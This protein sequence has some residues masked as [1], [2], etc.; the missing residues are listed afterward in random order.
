MLP[1]LRVSRPAV[2]RSKVVL[3]QPLGPSRQKSSPGSMVKDT[4]FSACTG[5]SPGKIFSTSL[6][7]MREL[8]YLYLLKSSPEQL[9]ARLVALLLEYCVGEPHGQIFADLGSFGVIIVNEH[10]L[11]Q[12]REGPRTRGIGMHDPAL[13][14]F[15]DD[16]VRIQRGE[17]I[18]E[19]LGVLR[20]GAALQDAGAVEP[21]TGSILWVNGNDRSPIVD[22]QG[23]V[24]FTGYANGIFAP[25]NS[26]W[27]HG[28][29][30]GED[31][32]LAHFHAEIEAI[33]FIHHEQLSIGRSRKGRVGQDDFPFVLGISQ[34]LPGLGIIFRSQ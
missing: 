23:D 9:R 32:V 30:G 5:G 25:G 3:P 8:T 19:Q 24:A 27:N 15:H 31:G 18:H 21:G 11:A 26:F 10:D 20:I 7:L 28:G 1:E 17:E 6:Y 34:V 13:S 22:G 12:G 29:R 16:A 2:Q 33:Q 4:F 14:G